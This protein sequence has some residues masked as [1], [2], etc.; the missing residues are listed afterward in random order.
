MK[1]EF[2]P[3]YEDVYK[4]SEDGTIYSYRKKGTIKLLAQFKQAVGYTI[5]NLYKDKQ[6]KTFLVHRLVM[7]TFGPPHPLPNIDYV[8]THSDRDKDNNHISNL[9]WIRR[10]KVRTRPGMPVK[11][12]GVDDNDVIRFRTVTATSIYF[13]SNQGLIRKAINSGKVYKGYIFE[14]IEK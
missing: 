3:G 12:T 2:I 13:H 9:H 11:A 8:V 5:V 7:S 4:I 1:T 14:D 10:D 6:R